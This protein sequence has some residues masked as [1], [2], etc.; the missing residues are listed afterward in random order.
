[1]GKPDLGRYREI[2]LYL[3]MGVLAMGV[4]LGTYYL[5]ADL[6]GLHYQAANILSWIFAVAFAYVT[7]KKYVFRTPYRGVR[8]TLREGAAFVGA[9][10]FSLGVEVVSMYLLVEGARF[11]DGLVKLFNQVLVTVLNYLFSKFWI[12]RRPGQ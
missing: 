2:L 10:L 11:D 4:S 7:N 12:F 5:L 3:V 9:R 1:M 8:A 6:L